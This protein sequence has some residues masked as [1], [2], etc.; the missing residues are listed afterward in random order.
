VF[1]SHEAATAGVTFE[2]QSQTDPL[3][4]LRYFGPD[5]NPDMPEVGD[6]AR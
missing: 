1:I 3:V 5:V 6:H 2:N 4:I